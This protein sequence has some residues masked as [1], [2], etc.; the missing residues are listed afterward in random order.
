MQWVVSWC[1]SGLTAP[2]GPR[3]W[4]E[5]MG[6]KR[7]GELLVEKGA[8]T[9]EQLDAG[10]AAH[11]RTR[12][13]L[14]VTLV[15]QGAITEQQ[16]AH[17]LG[18][19]FELPVVEL[20]KLQ[21]D[22]SAIHLLRARFCEQ[23]S[24]FPMALETVEGRRQ[25]TV[26]MVDPLDT[27][28]VQGIEFTT[29]M[30][31]VRRVATLGAV[32]GS[33]QRYYHKPL[34]APARPAP[35]ETRP[36]EEEPVLVGEEL[37]EVYAQQRKTLEELIAQREL[38]ARQGRQEGRQAGAPVDGVAAELEELIGGLE[39]ARAEA[40]KPGAADPAAALEVLERRFWGLL[41]ILARKG[42]LTREE[43][44]RELD[45]EP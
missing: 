37:S 31:V 33:I 2:G 12:Q 9:Q 20:E 11:R 27:A 36:P 39:Q 44:L 28:A 45:G 5:G 26:A 41:R 4:A 43:F 15:A 3:V 25:L 35:V 7:I 10:L 1:G 16:L 23:H 19:L 21:P 40:G 30:K 42:L 17:A 14:G 18:D 29:G 24:L 6:R 32:R 8:I 22:W 13:R 34:A 38:S